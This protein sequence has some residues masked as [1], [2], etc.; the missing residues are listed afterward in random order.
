MQMIKF[1]VLDV[2]AIVTDLE[3]IKISTD[4]LMP[5][6]SKENLSQNRLVEKLNRPLK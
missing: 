3:K 1:K 4:F 2:D 5:N 6:Y